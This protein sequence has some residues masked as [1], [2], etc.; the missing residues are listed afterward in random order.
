MDVTVSTQIDRPTAEVAQFAMNP[1]NEPRWI[2]GIKSARLLSPPPVG[3]GA[4][5]EAGGRFSGQTLQLCPAG[6][7][8]RAGPQGRHDHPARSFPMR[9]TYRFDPADQGRG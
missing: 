4:Q 3:V 1:E 6:R 7:R 8:V 9:V 5:V 2:G